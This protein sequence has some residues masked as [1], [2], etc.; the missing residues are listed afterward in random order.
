MCRRIKFVLLAAINVFVFV[1]GK[2]ND[3]DYEEILD[4]IL[5]LQDIKVLNCWRHICAERIKDPVEL[6]NVS[7]CKDKK[8]LY[9]AHCVE[10]WKF[11]HSILVQ[12]FCE[13]APFMYI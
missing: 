12:N 3:E 8:V 11:S 10:I 13:I 6:D 7:D 5:P 9:H 2:D 4:V 1:H